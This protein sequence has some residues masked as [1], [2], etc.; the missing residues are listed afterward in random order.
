MPQV[1]EPPTLTLPPD[2]DVQVMAARAETAALVP[3]V[4]RAV[5]VYRRQLA[6]YLAVTGADDVERDRAFREANDALMASEAW[7]LRDVLDV[8]VNLLATVDVPATVGSPLRGD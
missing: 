8:L 3:A 5:S 2:L 7:A 6:T 1:K 4:D